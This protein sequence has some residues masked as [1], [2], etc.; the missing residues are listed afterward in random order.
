MKPYTD[1]EAGRLLLRYGKVFVMARHNEGK[2][3]IFIL[4][5]SEVNKELRDEQIIR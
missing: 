2:L 3:E 5:P 1:E 4:E